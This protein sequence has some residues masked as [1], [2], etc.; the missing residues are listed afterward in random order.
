MDPCSTL[1][2][3]GLVEYAAQ[4]IIDY[5]LLPNSDVTPEPSQSISSNTIITKFSK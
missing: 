5:K 2:L 1:Q 4:Y 3:I